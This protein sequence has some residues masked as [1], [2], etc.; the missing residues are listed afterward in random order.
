MVS[1]F[2]FVVCLFVVCV[3][4]VYVR[5]VLY[6]IWYVVYVCVSRFVRCLC[7]WFRLVF[8]I[9]GQYARRLRVCFVLLV[10]D[11]CV[12]LRYAVYMCFVRF[13]CV[14]V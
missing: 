13:V 10:R 12:C 7:V 14:C 6:L 1:S 11:V 8:W 4:L 3:F 5:C 2:D 9:C